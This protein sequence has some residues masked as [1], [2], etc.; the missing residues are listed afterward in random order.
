ME[1]RELGTRQGRAGPELHSLEVAPLWLS[2]VGRGACEQGG[3][4]WPCFCTSLQVL[5]TSLPT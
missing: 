2:A 5:G 1:V 4:M 3:G